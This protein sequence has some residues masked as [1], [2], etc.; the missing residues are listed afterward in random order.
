ME[1][2]AD[3]SLNNFYKFQIIYIS[4]KLQ[5]ANPYNQKLKMLL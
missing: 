1:Y 5:A 2:T 4:W 3:L